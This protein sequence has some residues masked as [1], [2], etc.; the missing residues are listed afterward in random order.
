[1]DA[2]GA[3]GPG[4]KPVP[5]PELT[6]RTVQGRQLEL[7]VNRANSRRERAAIQRLSKLAPPQRV[8]KAP[9]RRAASVPRRRTARLLWWV[10]GVAAVA[11]VVVLIVA[12]HSSGLT[13]EAT[14]NGLG[15]GSVSSCIVNGSTV[16]VSGQFEHGVGDAALLGEATIEIVDGSGTPLGGFRNPRGLATFTAGSINWTLP[17]PYSGGKPSSCRVAMALVLAPLIGIPGAP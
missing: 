8:A 15:T 17:V 11:L 9:K 16:V 4:S 6:G 13:I 1:M 10:W 7:T 5:V 2:D 14:S 3:M 12:T